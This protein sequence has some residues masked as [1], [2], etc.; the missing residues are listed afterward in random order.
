MTPEIEREGQ[1]LYAY[2]VIFSG[3][4]VAEFTKALDKHDDEIANWLSILPNTVF[5]AS[6]LSATDLSNFL[7]LNVADIKNILVLD[8]NTDRNGW[9][10][11]SAW[12]FF[13][14]PKR[15]DPKVRRFIQ[16]LKRL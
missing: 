11:K 16:K 14:H 7:R 10:S 2:V 8:A 12:E 3:T 15:V 1:Q 4:S 6:A 9:L 5:I 13:K